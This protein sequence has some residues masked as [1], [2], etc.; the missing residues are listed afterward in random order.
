MND[1]TMIQGL[2]ALADPT[3]L[4]IVKFLSN[5]CCQSVTMQEDGGIEGAT[6]GE[7]CCYVTGAPKIN[8]TISH[9]LHELEAAGIIEM[10][11]RG[12]TTICSLKVERL[13]ELAH[14]IA[15]IEVRETTEA[16]C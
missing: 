8:S 15:G 1:E 4:D 14:Q 3:R 10:T 13:R 2:K 12:K 9:H 6:A 7:V 5:V 11:K 16:C